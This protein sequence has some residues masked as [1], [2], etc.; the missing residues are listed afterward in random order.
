MDKNQFG[1]TSELHLEALFKDG[2]TCL[3]DVTFTAPFKIMHPFYEKKD[4]MTVMLQIASAGLL[5]G[6]RQIFDLQVRE[7]AS[8]EFLSQSYEKIH[9]MPAGHA[10]RQVKIKVEKQADLSYTPLPVI[11]FRDA[12]FRSDT[13][14]E[15]VDETARFVMTEVLTC[16]R[17]AYGEEFLFRRFRNRVSIFCGGQL[18]YR[19]NTLYQPSETDMTGFG[20][21]E[22]YSH[23]GNMVFCNQQKDA[24]W[25]KQVRELLDS[26]EHA[27]GGVTSAASGAVVVRMLG[28]SGDTLLKLQEQILD[29]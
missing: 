4:R 15:L 5:E 12:D 28:R 16:G 7:G 6:D 26:A 8:M 29:L 19:D 2:R 23:L 17:V 18:I 3:G 9:R 10:E 25:M 11:P 14:V 24:D 22:G 13:E 27:E 20:M 21:Y 1:K